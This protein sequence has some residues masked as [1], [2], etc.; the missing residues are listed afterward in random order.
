MIVSTWTR[1]EVRA[2]RTAALRLTQEQ[3]AERL[4][5]QPPTVRKWERTT[6]QRP[7]RGESAQALD[8]QLARLT[9]EQRARFRATV[10]NEYA[11]VP[12]LH[13]RRPAAEQRD[14]LA[15]ESRYSVQEVEDDVKRREFG[16]LFGAALIAAGDDSSL[17]QGRIGTADARRLSE[18][19]ADFAQ[20]EQAIGGVTLVRTAVEGLERAKSLLETCTFSE[21]AGREFMSATG[22][23]ATIAGW[24]AYDSDMHPVARQ[25]YA[26][27]FALA[28]QAGDDEL[29]THVCLNAAHQ[30]IALSRAGSSNPHR[31]LGHLHRA[32]CLTSGQ[33]PG[34][35]H[36][37]IATRE[38]LA[39]GLLG[40]RRAFERAISTAWRELDN[41]L[42]HEAI[43]DCPRWLRFVNPT[44]VR[45]HE[46]RGFED[47]GE[48]TRSAELLAD[49][50]ALE[51]AGA[52]NAACYRAG[53]AA[54][55]ANIGDIN[56][57][58]TQGL[59]VLDSLETSVTSTRTLRLLTPVRSAA[60]SSPDSEFRDRFDSLRHTM[61][62]SV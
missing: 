24:M 25:C 33:P 22:E 55:L 9:D 12:K 56:G 29:T 35:V 6:R 32:R 57:A 48:L 4:G 21:Q 42:D 51:R 1:V 2:L 26:D 11:A 39:Y 61:V 52:R 60:A 31:V 54:T 59:S 49:E 50:P 45:S 37:L 27:A 36:A 3:F 34:R 18:S 7:V 5:Y 14:S 16:I 46:A 13:D 53:W 20:R 38:A 40:D 30:S 62:G 41:A 47:L 43:A 10:E 23:L 44:E 19:V 28:N 17:T 8:T 58:V 15:V